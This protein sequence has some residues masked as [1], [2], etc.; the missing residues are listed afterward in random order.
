M[1]DDG[2]SLITNSNDGRKGMDPADRGVPRRGSDRQ[3]IA[4]TMKS[5]NSPLAR[6]L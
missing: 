4:A 6:Y 3:S 2:K 1:D 5:Y